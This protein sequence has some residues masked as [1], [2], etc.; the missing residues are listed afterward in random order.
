[1]QGQKSKLDKALRLLSPSLAQPF[2]N[3]PDKRRTDIN[4]IRLRNKRYLTAVVKSNEYYITPSGSF[5]VDS[6]NAIQ[7]AQEEIEYTYKTALRNTIYSYEREISL[8]YIIT[9]GGNRVGF[10]GTAVLD[11]R[12]K[13]Q[14]LKNISSISIRI[15]REIFG[16]ANDL[17]NKLELQDNELKNVLILG[18]PSSG[19]TTL[20]RDLCRQIGMKKRISIIDEKNEISASFKGYPQN[21]VGNFTDVFDSYTKYCGILS[22]VKIMSPQLIVCDEIG[23]KEDLIALDYAINSGVNI[24]ATMHS[25]S[26]DDA[27]RKPYMKDL[28]IRKAFDYIVLLGTGDSIGKVIDIRKIEANSQM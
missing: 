21:N 7:I 20:I 4:E 15:A 22:A 10:C 17:I 13:N 16:I 23:T 5:S 18:P 27:F 26:I 11:D 19:K 2:Y 6:D 3:M 8:G 28:F 14:T 1:M 12:G 25:S 24:I 9:E